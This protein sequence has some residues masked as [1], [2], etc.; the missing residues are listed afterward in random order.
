MKEDVFSFSNI[1]VDNFKILNNLFIFRVI[2]IHLN[3]FGISVLNQKVLGDPD[4]LGS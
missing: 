1:S 3:I 2:E 4:I